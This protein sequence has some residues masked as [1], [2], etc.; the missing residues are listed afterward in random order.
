MSTGL[1][2]RFT[3]M[4]RIFQRVARF[5]MREGCPW[6]LDKKKGLG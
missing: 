3:T 2:R 5:V 6:G 4:Q 1:D